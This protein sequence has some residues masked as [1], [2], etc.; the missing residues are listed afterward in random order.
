MQSPKKSWVCNLN[1]A[2]LQH[3]SLGLHL[4]RH[5]ELQD[6]GHSLAPGR[7]GGCQD[8]HGGGTL[9][10]VD[11]N[12]NN[13][14]LPCRCCDS[15][16]LRLDAKLGLRSQP[17][18]PGRPALEAEE[19]EEEEEDLGSPSEPSDPVS[20]SVSSC[21]DLSLEESPVSV[22]FRA[23]PAAEAASPDQQPNIVPLEEARYLAS[24]GERGP[25]LPAERPAS[26]VR[27]SPDSL[28]S[29]G[30]VGSL[31]DP[32]SPGPE[33][34]LQLPPSLAPTRPCRA[35]PAV[36]VSRTATELDSNCNAL[37]A[38]ETEPGNRSSPGPLDVN[39]N[40]AWGPPP[41]PPR[42]KRGL[43]GLKRGEAGKPT[44]PPAQPEPSL[45]PDPLPGEGPRKTV[46]SFHELAQKRKR[47]ATAPPLPPAP[48]ARKDQSDWLIVFS[49]D[50]ELPPCNELTWGPP[51]VPAEPPVS[52]QEPGDP[53][54]C[55]QRG[56]T[57]FKELRHRKQKGPPAAKGGAAPLPPQT[58][59][60]KGVPDGG[61]AQELAPELPPSGRFWAANEAQPRRK[62]CRPGLQPIVEGGLEDGED[63]RAEQDPPAGGLEGSPMPRDPWMPG[64]AGRGERGG[65]EGKSHVGQTTEGRPVGVPFDGVQSCRPPTFCPCPPLPGI[66][67]TVEEPARRQGAW[68]GG[69]A[70]D[71]KKRPAGSGPKPCTKGRPRK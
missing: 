10:E 66:S 5:P 71:P 26:R 7:Q 48:Q 20:S 43:L 55:A 3:I 12:S 37:P 40:R 65:T 9:E 68:R 32:S 62:K 34:P 64:R 45:G 8:C 29:S 27:D 51:P 70:S 6:D 44:P 4:S 52:L 38:R 57:T 41:V 22:Y 25:D 42:T 23:L 21:S 31:S 11:A 17:L 1:H 16:L 50:T 35:P 69:Q 54:G 36:P 60:A 58:E 14:S 24:R 63:G 15:H 2:H 59:P 18:L 46:T 33:S 61:A 47:A 49:P 19:E 39:L 28:C 56:V 13:P 53:T 67:G 30:S